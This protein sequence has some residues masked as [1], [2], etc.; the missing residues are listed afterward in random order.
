VPEG[1]EARERKA[2]YRVTQADRDGAFR[3]EGLT[4]GSY[5]VFAWNDVETQPGGTQ[6]S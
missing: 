5:K 6:S 3:M 4:P 1:A 2:L